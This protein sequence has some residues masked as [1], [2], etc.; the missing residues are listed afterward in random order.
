M[1][2]A[3]MYS[4]TDENGVVHITNA[5]QQDARY[6]PI[7]SGSSQG[8]VNAAP[9]R[10]RRSVA[11]YRP[12]SNAPQQYR[13]RFSGHIERAA[14]AYNVDSALLHAVISVESGYNPR[15]CSPKGAMGLMQ[16]M[17][18]T[19]RRYGVRNPYDPVQN[20]RGGA[21]Y[22]RD[23]LLRY[24]N[25][26][27]LALAAYNA[28]ENSVARYGNNIPPYAETQNYVPRVVDLYMR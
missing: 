9:R 25:D 16:L 13:R 27:N 19:A 14:Q 11:S 1:S 21:R 22:L 10:Q 2:V 8:T 15:A 6:A 12:Q 24:D 17:P 7:T 28:G 26:V 3:E 18:A 20:I 4:Y 5:P 23:L